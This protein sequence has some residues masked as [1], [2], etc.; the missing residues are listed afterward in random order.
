MVASSYPLSSF[1]TVYSISETDGTVIAGQEQSGQRSLIRLLV[2]MSLWLTLPYPCMNSPAK[3]GASDP[4]MGPVLAAA[5]LFERPSEHERM[6][7]G[8]SSS[9]WW[10]NWRHIRNLVIALSLLCQWLSPHG[11]AQGRGLP[12]TSAMLWNPQNQS[13]LSSLP[14]FKISAMGTSSCIVFGH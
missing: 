1:I 4:G 8:L 5:R 14:S 7:M 11:L 6:S 3:L 2:V 9:S 13:H 10:G 12:V